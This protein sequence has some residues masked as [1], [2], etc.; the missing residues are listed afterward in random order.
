MLFLLPFMSNLPSRKS[1]ENK[2]NYD[3]CVSGGG[4]GG[5]NCQILKTGGKENRQQLVKMITCLNFGLKVHSNLK[6]S[7]KQFVLQ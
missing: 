3:G 4:G 2:H 6:P 1:V 7:D 5:I